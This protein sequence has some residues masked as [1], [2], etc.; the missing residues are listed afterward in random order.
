VAVK[1]RQPC[2]GPPV[3]PNRLHQVRPVPRRPVLPRGSA[4]GW[5]SGR[6]PVRDDDRDRQLP[7]PRVAVAVYLLVPDQ[8]RS[9]TSRTLGAPTL[10]RSSGPSWVCSASA[11]CCCPTS[12]V[13]ARSHAGCPCTAWSGAS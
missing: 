13:S 2:T 12:R 11:S 4:T 1:R 7:R 6:R 10:T 9:A 5:A 8:A 3:L